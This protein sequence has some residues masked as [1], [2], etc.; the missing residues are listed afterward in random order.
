MEMLLFHYGKD[1]VRKVNCAMIFWLLFPAMALF[2]LI[3]HLRGDVVSF[4][5]FVGATSVCFGIFTLHARLRLSDVMVGDD[6]ISWVMCGRVWKKIY[7]AEVAKIRVMTL[8][9]P[10]TWGLASRRRLKI[11]G[12]W[13]TTTFTPYFLPSGGMAFDDRID[14]GG[15]L[16]LIVANYAA[17]YKIEIE[18]IPAT[19]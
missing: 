2:P 6:S 10:R 7:W 3:G 15:K 19:A 5:I 14:D 12:V 13:K 11:C 4:E 18:T 9:L 17:Q 8:H 1:V 16:L